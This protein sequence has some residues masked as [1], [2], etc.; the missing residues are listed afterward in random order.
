[1]L[2]DD[3]IAK[4]NELFV[5]PK[6]YNSLARAPV[7]GVLDRVKFCAVEKQQQLVTI[8]PHSLED[9]KIWR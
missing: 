7:N 1:M 2:R 8:T 4:S 6:A 3:N 9:Y 5:L